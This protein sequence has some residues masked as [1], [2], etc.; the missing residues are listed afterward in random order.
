V[1]NRI[2]HFAAREMRSW[3]I[4]LSTATHSSDGEQPMPLL[5]TPRKTMRPHLNPARSSNRGKTATD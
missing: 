3:R 5:R 1:P 2:W 4:C